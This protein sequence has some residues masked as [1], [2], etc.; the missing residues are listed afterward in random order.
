MCECVGEGMCGGRI[1]RE[2][3]KVWVDMEERGVWRRCRGR[4][5]GE[6]TGL[7]H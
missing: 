7:T 4:G 6:G 2:E 3:G 5:K 1:W